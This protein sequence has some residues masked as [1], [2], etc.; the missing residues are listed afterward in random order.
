VS[1]AASITV[2]KTG[3]GKRYVVR[4]RLGGRG[5]PVLH[6]GSFTTMKEA[7][8]RRDLVAGE[9]AAGRNPRELLDAQQAAERP[10]RCYGDW[11]D[12]FVSSR[13]DVG[14]ATLL[15]YRRHRA[16]LVELV[17]DRDPFRLTPADCQELV[18]KLA[19]NM[20][21]GSVEKWVTTFRLVLDFAGVDPN[22]AR[23]RRV[24]LPGYVREEPVPPTSRQYLAI[25]EQLRPARHRLPVVLIE[26][27]GM[28]IAEVL[29]LTWGDMDVAGCQ[30]RLRRSQT[31]TKAARWVQIPEWLV[32]I[33]AATCPL[34]DRLAD[35][36]VLPGLTEGMVR[37]AI[38]R[39]CKAAKVPHYHPHDFRHRRASLWHGQG[40]PAAELAKRLGHA[41]PSMSLDVYSHVMPVDEAE[42]EALDA[43]L[44]WS[45]CGPEP[46]RPDE[47]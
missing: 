46:G 35:R 40:V 45:R 28:R 2:R 12:A 43:L 17:D 1:G 10:T 37:K 41:R 39:A 36:R 21:P 31:K 13:L 11:H 47:L 42:I 26:Q 33:I 5:F 14:A 38:T 15:G 25:L 7:R 24:K 8:L 4:Y 19:A 30:A 44:V 16:R 32:S 3:S 23:D 27:T 22:P 29:E 6:A 18:A 9:L 20:K 34:E